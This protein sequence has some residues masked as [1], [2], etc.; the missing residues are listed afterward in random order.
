ML[1]ADGGGASDWA[2]GEAD[3]DPV[4]E[5]SVAQ[6]LAARHAARGVELEVPCGVLAGGEAQEVR[7]TVRLGR[8]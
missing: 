5:G 1:E 4:A 2:W 7:L 6:R 8:H 3:L